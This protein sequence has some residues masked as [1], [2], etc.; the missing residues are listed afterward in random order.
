MT[1]FIQPDRQYTLQEVAQH[2]GLAPYIVRYWEIHFPQ[3]A[4][5][6]SS[7]NLYSS[8]DVA[9]IWRIKKLLYV[10]H[11]TIDQAKEK[12]VSELSFP[13]QYP[14]QATAVEAQPS[15]VENEPASEALQAES[16]PEAAEPVSQVAVEVESDVQVSES[17]PEEE[18]VPATEESVE[19][20][21][22]LPQQ[23]QDSVDREEIDRLTA[24]IDALQ[25]QVAVL[26]DAREAIMRE[27]EE[28][29]ARLVQVGNE[30]ST[31]D[32]GNA[33]LKMENE[34]LKKTIEEVISQLKEM[35][36]TLLT[37]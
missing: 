11:L 34:Q 7:K 36:T 30:Q 26:T 1:D 23:T 12:L 35:S 32:A 13:V 15:A 17:I 14:G 10:D 3:L 8:N 27:N 21:E 16:T 19:Q 5:G 22:A 6:N 28:L 29:K 25:Q 4:G 20:A 2:C 24:Q 18:P 31:A 33:A 37:R 9:L